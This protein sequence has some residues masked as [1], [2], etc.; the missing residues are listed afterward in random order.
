MAMEALERIRKAE[1]EAKAIEQ[2][3]KEKAAQI[4]AD[5]DKNGKKI[6][7]NAERQGLAEREEILKN[8]KQTCEAIASADDKA[9]RN[10]ADH[11]I[12]VSDM[13]MEGAVSLI[14]DEVDRLWQ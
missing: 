7:E 12:S 11:L 8:A 5:A 1:E 13:R 14:L 3:G 2:S 4:L 6:C 10:E 9:A